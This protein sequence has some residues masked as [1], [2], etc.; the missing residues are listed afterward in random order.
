MK[1]LLLGATGT[2]GRA[3]RADLLAHT[4]YHLTLVS[5]HIEGIQHNSNRETVVQADVHDAEL[6]E[7]IIKD[8]DVIVSALSAEGDDDELAE[9]ARNVVSAMKASG[10]TRLIFMVA[11][12]IYDEIPEAIDGQDNVSR[13]PGQIHNLRAAKV[14]ENSE[15]DY[16]LLR[17]GYLVSG[18]DEIE[19]THKGQPVTGYRT[20]VEGVGKTVR[21]LISGEL[22]GLR[23]SLGLN[24]PLDKA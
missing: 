17:P 15:L 12:G 21:K 20:S 4:N 1:V 5:R 2:A 10:A 22:E 9:L 11:M 24:L 8:Q 3:I 23:D 16:T 18:S 19:V 13:N 14:V 7:R 6:L